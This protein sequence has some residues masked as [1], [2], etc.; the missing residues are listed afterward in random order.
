MINLDD[1]KIYIDSHKMEMVP[2]SIAK[3]AV[4]DMKEKAQI[5]QLDEAIK[6]LSEELT[7][8]KPDL[9]ILNDKDS[10]RKS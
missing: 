3:Q 1:H 10:T 5:E 7:S 4:E 6:T 8:L 9:S 2:L